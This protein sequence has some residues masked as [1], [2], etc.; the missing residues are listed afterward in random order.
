MKS[1]QPATKKR[2]TLWQKLWQQ[3]YKDFIT[4]IREHSTG[5]TDKHYDL[6]LRQLFKF[7]PEKT[8]DGYTR[9]DIEAFIRSPLTSGQPPAQNTRCCRLIAIKSFYAYC[10]SYDVMYRRAYRQICTKNP[11][12]LIRETQQTPL[13]KDITIEEWERFFSVI[14]DNTVIGKRDQALYMLYFL[15]GRRRAEICSMLREDIEQKD[16]VWY[17][18]WLGKRRRVK[19]RRQLPVAGLD[20]IREYLVADGRDLETM[21][22][23]DPVFRSSRP[24][25]PTT[26]LQPGTIDERFRLYARLAGI[27][28][29]AV[30]HNIRRLAGRIRHQQNGRDLANTAEFLDHKS[31]QQTL[32]YV[33]EDQEY[34]PD[35]LADQTAAAYFK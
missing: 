35:P 34:K 23:H 31:P 5:D 28:D 4:Y 7:L 12:S 18:S 13:K 24:N 14:D 6:H 9:A 27:P 32:R 1:K 15:T 8:P 17:Y 26:H 30:Q 2:A 19:S 22:P 33:L 16:G 3:C 10:L 21:A 11:A 20:A 25:P 29:E